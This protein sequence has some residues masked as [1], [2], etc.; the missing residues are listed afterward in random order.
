MVKSAFLRLFLEAKKKMCNPIRGY[1]IPKFPG[2]RALF[3]SVFPSG[4]MRPGSDRK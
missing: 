4:L 1:R 3:S 2:L